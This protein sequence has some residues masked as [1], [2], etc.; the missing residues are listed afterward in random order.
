MKLRLNFEFCNDS[1][2]I[3]TDLEIRK[4]QQKTIS[5]L[6]ISLPRV[7]YDTVGRRSS[8]MFGLVIAITATTVSAFSPNAYI[9]MIHRF[10]QGK[11]D[12]YW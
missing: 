6:V 12:R 5:R 4:I 8:A 3:S 2:S 9:I 7:L 10:L 11:L 1:D